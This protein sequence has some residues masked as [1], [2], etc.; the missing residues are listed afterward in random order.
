MNFI[1]SLLMVTARI[2]TPILL[3]STGAIYSEKS[4]LPNISL[5]AAMIMGSWLFME[6]FFMLI[7]I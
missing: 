7:Q 5:D 1:Y 4:G 3:A 2:S 6:V